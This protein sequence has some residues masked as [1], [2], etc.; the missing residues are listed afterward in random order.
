MSEI[1]FVFRRKD[2]QLPVLKYRYLFVHVYCIECNKENSWN[3][4]EW[5]PRF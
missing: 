2:S 5:I 3:S 4:T 1:K